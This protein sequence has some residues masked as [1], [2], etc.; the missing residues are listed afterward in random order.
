MATGF[1]IFR[2]T[3]GEWLEEQVNDEAMLESLL[4]AAIDDYESS[5]IAEF[6]LRPEAKL[7]IS[8]NT[9]VT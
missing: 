6:E 7:L 1:Y 9:F 5:Q 3:V 8:N 4:Q 2:G